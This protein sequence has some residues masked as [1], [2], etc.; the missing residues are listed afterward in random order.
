MIAQIGRFQSTDQA[1]NLF[2][3]RLNTVLNP[4]LNNELNMG[5]ILTKVS[6][7]SG[8]NIIN[9]GLGRT[10]V[11]WFPVRVRANATIYDTQ[12]TNTTPQ[13]TLLLTASA[14]VVVDLFIF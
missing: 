9:H 11:G 5:N 6:L 3:D 4:I 12:D 7:A 2:Q 8:A 13:L 14:A 1:F 10:L